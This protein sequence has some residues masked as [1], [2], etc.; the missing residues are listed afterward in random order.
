MKKGRKWMLEMGIVM[1]MLAGCHS[2]TEE[3]EQATKDDYSEIITESVS[4]A[5][6]VQNDMLPEF[7]FEVEVATPMLNKLLSGMGLSYMY[8]GTEKITTLSDRTMLGLIAGVIIDDGSYEKAWYDETVGGYMI[9]QD[10][11]DTYTMDLFGKRIDLSGFES[12]QQIGMALISQNHEYFALVGDWGLSCPTYVISGYNVL[13]DG[14]YHV[15]AMFGVTNYEEET[16][17]YLVKAECVFEV[18]EESKYG[19]IIRQMLIS[20]I[21]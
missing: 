3:I 9:P 6:I 21:E 14:N 4:N 7:D 17:E 18:C 13:D 5:A 12:D 11:V 10:I 8:E 2:K 1:M 19:Y 20:Y 15:D 16:T